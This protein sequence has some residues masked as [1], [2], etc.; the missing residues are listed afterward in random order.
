MINNFNFLIEENMLRMAR[1]ASK[2]N[3]SQIGPYL[4]KLWQKQIWHFWAPNGA[5]VTFSKL[6][7]LK[8]AQNIKIWHQ[9]R[10]YSNHLFFAQL[11]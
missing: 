11:S 10:K 8:L 2:Q 6:L 7:T 9:V 3:F 5:K 4:T 1:S